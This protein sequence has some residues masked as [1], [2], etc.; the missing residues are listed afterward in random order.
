MAGSGVQKVRGKGIRIN[1]RGGTED[2]G[3]YERSLELVGPVL[4]EKRRKAV[5]ILDQL[6]GTPKASE[7]IEEIVPAA[8]GGRVKILFVEL[9]VQRWRTFDIATQRAAAI[10]RYP[11]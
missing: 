3:L 2:G 11:R 10:F 1:G 8:Y 7:K 9:G 4:L 5:E 6:R